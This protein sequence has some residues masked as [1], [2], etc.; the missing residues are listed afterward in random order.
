VARDDP[1]SGLRL[2]EQTSDGKLDQRLF[3]PQP[4][5]P[6]APKPEP[7]PATEP[8]KPAAKPARPA[9]PQKQPKQ[10]ETHKLLASP[11]PRFDLGDEPLYKASYLFTQ[12][13][14]EALE[15]LKLELRRQY[16]T[17]VT[18]ND[19]MRSALH[20]LLE[21]HAANSLRSYA[22]RK[23]RNRKPGA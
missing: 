5:P 14:L 21:D 9:Q 7:P 22:N 16:D 4:A 18:K 11:A 8:A 12:A 3:A 13:E 10:P 6:P 23:I 20:L 19:L 1:F 2:S 17:K 15:D